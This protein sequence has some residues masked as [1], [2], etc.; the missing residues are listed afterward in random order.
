MSWRAPF[1]WLTRDWAE[2]FLPAEVNDDATD[3]LPKLGP[4][5]TPDASAGTPAHA[6]KA[7]PTATFTRGATC[8]TRCRLL[9]IGQTPMSA[10]RATRPSSDARWPVK[11]GAM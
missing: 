7:S 3:V 9:T 10:S 1:H 8:S 6:R 4:C 11:I 2:S 5:P